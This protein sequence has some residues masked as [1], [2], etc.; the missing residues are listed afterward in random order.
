MVPAGQPAALLDALARLREASG[1]AAELA[2]AGIAYAEAHT[3]ARRCLERAANLVD[4][5]AGRDPGAD[6]AVPAAA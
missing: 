5:I 2:A 4:L 3:G 1:L 6:T